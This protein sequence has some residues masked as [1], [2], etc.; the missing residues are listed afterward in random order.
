[1]LQGEC[2]MSINGKAPRLLVAGDFIL[3]P[4]TYTFETTSDQCQPSSATGT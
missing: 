2:L 1:M 4:A 3:I